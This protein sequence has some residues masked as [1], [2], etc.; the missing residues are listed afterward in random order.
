MWCMNGI[1]CSLYTDTDERGIILKKI[2]FSVL[3][4][5]LQVANS[6]AW[7]KYGKIW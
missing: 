7:T 3:Q 5:S 2:G 4:Y 6:N 1:E